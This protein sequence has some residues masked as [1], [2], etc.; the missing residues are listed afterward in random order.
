ML[1]LKQ[2]SSSD[3]AGV[4]CRSASAVTARPAPI[5]APWATTASLTCSAT[6]A[7]SATEPGCGPVRPGEVVEFLLPYSEVCMSMRVAG[8]RMCVRLTEAGMAQLLDEHGHHFSS[9]ICPAKRAVPPSR[10]WLLRARHRAACRG[11]TAPARDH[12]RPGVLACSVRE[13]WCRRMAQAGT[14]TPP[15]D[16]VYACELLCRAAP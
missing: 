3:S 8:R 2:Q 14:A 11:D 16:P 1:R 10:W 12:E 13:L 9:P 5:V 7:V 15:H 4:C 6:A